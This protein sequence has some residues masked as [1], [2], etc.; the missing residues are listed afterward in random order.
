M[1]YVYILKSILTNPKS[2]ALAGFLLALPIGL[3][4]TILVLEIQPLEAFLKP[5]FTSDS[6]RT[7]AFGLV[8]ILGGMLLLPVALVVSLWPM[9]R[10][11]ADGKRNLHGINLILALAIVALITFTWGGFVKDFVNCEVLNLPNCD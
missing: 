9:M 4:Y 7:N 11:D 5:L 2:A 3:L 8:T 1:K 10:R 6:G